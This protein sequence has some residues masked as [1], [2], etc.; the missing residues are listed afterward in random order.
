MLK[1]KDR[2]LRI[3]VILVIIFLVINLALFALRIISTIL[4]WAI[5]AV[6]AVFAY[7]LLPR[8]K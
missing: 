4:F 1:I 7:K 3:L 6:A 8:K 5:I 2:H